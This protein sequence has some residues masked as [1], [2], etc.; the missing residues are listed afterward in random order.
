MK[1][2]GQGGNHY[3]I[4]SFSPGLR[5]LNGFMQA[6]T[7]L[8]DYSKLAKD[9]HARAL[10]NS[11]DRSARRE[12]PHFDT[13]AWSLYSRSGA[14]STLGYHR[15]VRDFLRN[16]CERT[17]KA[18]YCTTQRRFTDYLRKPTKVGYIGARGAKARKPA[19]IRFRLNK[20]SCVIVTVKRGGQTVFDRRVK[21]FRDER[22][23]Q[24]TPQRAGRYEVT[25]EVL[26]LRRNKSTA[27][28]TITVRSGR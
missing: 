7:G 25:L 10:F 23:V 17:R 15:L 22:F 28:G 14:E 5:V 9:R 20:V 11:G 24:F 8:Y 2:R 12:I 3:L 19:R 26:D 21:L 1:A 6:L 13:G 18:H 4:Y 27:T 16:L